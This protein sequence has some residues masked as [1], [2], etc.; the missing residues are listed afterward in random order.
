MAEVGCGACAGAGWQ[1]SHAS[2]IFATL[3]KKQGPR[4]PMEV[5]TF[6][7]ILLPSCW[8]HASSANWPGLKAPPVIGE[9]WPAFFSAEPARLDRTLDR[10]QAAR[11]DRHHPAAVRSR[12]RN[13]CHAAGEDRRQAVIVAIAGFCCR[14]CS[15]MASATTLRPKPAGVVVRGGTLTATSIGITVRRAHRSQRQDSPEAQVVLGAAVLTT[16]WAWCCSPS[17]TSSR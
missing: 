5:H 17:C 16:S 12:A 2:G 9:C 3:E 10:H 15:A 1:L 11:R 7:L 6:F 14:F 13:R 8:R 4:G